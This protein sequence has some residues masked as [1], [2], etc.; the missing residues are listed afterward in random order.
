MKIQIREKDGFHMTLLFPT[1]L[2]GTIIGSRIAA[3]LILKGIQF[4]GQ[5]AYETSEGQHLELREIVTEDMI[6]KAQKGLKKCLFG[7]RH[8]TLVE[9]ES[10]EGDFVKIVL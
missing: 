3:R 4:S 6:R 5:T 9:V 10:P 8:L 7:Y 2:I 1:S